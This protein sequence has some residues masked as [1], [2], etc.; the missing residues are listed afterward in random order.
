LTLPAPPAS[1]LV[2][3]ESLELGLLLAEGGEGRVYQLPLSPHLVYK[4]YRRPQPLDH[5]WEL[6]AWPS[7]LE[8]PLEARVRAGA[9]WPEAVVAD[10]EE[11]ALGLLLPRA[12]RRFG[13]RHRDGTTR[14]ASLSYL[15]ADPAHRAV[16][17]GISLPPPASPERLGLVYALARLLEAFEGRDPTVAHGDLSTKNVLWSLSRGPEVFVIDVDSAERF[18][19]SGNPLGPEGRRR[20]MTPNWDDPSVP[21]GQNPTPM[22]DRYSLALIF[23][24]VVGAA[25][26]PIQARQRSGGEVEVEFAIPPAGLRYLGPSSPIWQL[27]EAGLSLAHP[28][29]RPPASCWAQALEEL[30]VGSGHAEVVASVQANQALGAQ[31]RALGPARLATSRTGWAGEAGGNG[32]RARGSSPSARVFSGHPVE[33]VSIAVV[34]R[35]AD[36][37]VRWER[38]HGSTHPGSRGAA[39]AG[40][41]GLT[42][43][44][45]LGGQ[46]GVVGSLASGGSGGPGPL[47]MPKVRLPGQVGP[48]RHGLAVALGWWVGRHAG[49]LRL[50][51]KRGRRSQGVRAAAFCALVDLVVVA[52]AFFVT[53]TMA[54]GLLGL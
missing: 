40:A 28:A 8:A 11:E 20:A 2:S 32:L 52:V 45:G 25:N 15:T 4:R 51:V 35:Q 47:G 7:G 13:I 22:S 31:A 50:L 41:L 39:L 26:F 1:G 24:R 19:R 44:P 27:C 21:P 54:S 43:P 46:S 38:V 33:D 10:S 12:P 49:A 6:V 30:L 36:E 53:A 5:L 17:Y 14:L 42:G 23:L 3:S 29:K 34:A 16:A 18:D 9:A 37:E 48:I